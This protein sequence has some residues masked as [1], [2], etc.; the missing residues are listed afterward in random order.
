MDFHDNTTHMEGQNMGKLI[1]FDVDG[2]LYRRDCLV[3]ESTVR[4]IK[5]LEKNGHKAMVCTGRGACTLPAEVE[6]LPLHGGVCG[7]GTY[8]S[9]EDKVLTNTGVEGR[10]VKQVLA[11]MDKYGWPFFIE[12]ADYFYCDPDNMPEKFKNMVD[13]MKQMYAGHFRTIKESPDRIAKMTG[14]PSNK[15]LIPSLKAELSPWFNVIVHDEYDYIEITVKG[16]SKGTGALQ[17]MEALGAKPEDT[18][19]FGDSGNDIPMLDAVGTAIVMGDAP[20]E[21]KARYTAT[22]S[23]YADGVEKALLKL[24]LI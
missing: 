4:A 12:N 23:L 5:Q 16:Y 22:D 1:F 18:Y 3:P 10:D 13:R 17:I 24:G 20:E 8:V 7:C 9:I 6:A 11:I 21:L 2:T 15:E 19:G 14:Y